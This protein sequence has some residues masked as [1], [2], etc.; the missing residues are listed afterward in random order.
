M[1]KRRMPKQRQIQITARALQLFEQLQQIPRG[2]ERWYDVHGLLHKE[3]GA[4]V[5]EWPLDCNVGAHYW[6]AL[7]AAEAAES[8]RRQVAAAK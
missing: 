6:A 5:W 1:L 3:L 7:E 2:T 4:R 8:M